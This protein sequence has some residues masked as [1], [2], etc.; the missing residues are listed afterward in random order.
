MSANLPP[1]LQSPA[2][3]HPQRRRIYNLL[4]WLCFGLGFIGMVV[5]LMPTTVFWIGAAWLWL[6]SNP[7][8]V[9]FL[10]EHP[11]MGA[12]IRSFLE[13]GEICRTGK[14]AAVSSMAG[15]YVLWWWLVQPSATSAAIVA[16]ILGSVA[17][18][19]VSRPTRRPHPVAAPVTVTL[20]PSKRQ[21]PTL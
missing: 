2:D 5:P 18:W 15:S 3:L 20:T 6:R 1:Q 16:A 4:A 8:R 13:H 19:I 10:V 7:Q 12:S 21:P 11:S 9:R 14:T 17:V